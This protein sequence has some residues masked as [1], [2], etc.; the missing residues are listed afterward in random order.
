M[1]RFIAFIAVF[2][3][4]VAVAVP[5]ASGR[6]NATVDVADDFFD[7]ASKTIREDRTVDFVWVG[8]EDHDVY[9]QIGPGPNW[10]SGV[11]SG[12]GATYS[13][14]FRRPGNYVL[15]CTLHPDML[16][17]LKVKKRRRN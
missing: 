4:A 2:A 15:A 6:A 5:S 7:P 11:K 1:R 10:T 16:M 14:K 8:V 12:V 13:R 3:A 17:D 9:K